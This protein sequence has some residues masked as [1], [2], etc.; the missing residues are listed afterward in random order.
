MSRHIEKFLTGGAEFPLLSVSRIGAGSGGDGGVHFGGSDESSF[1]APLTINRQEYEEILHA[2]S[3]SVEVLRSPSGT[4][5][6]G[7]RFG[8]QSKRIAFFSTNNSGASTN[9]PNMGDGA[10]YA[11]VAQEFGYGFD[12]Y[13]LPGNSLS[14]V[15]SRK[16]RKRYARTGSFTNSDTSNSGLVLTDFAEEVM[17][18]MQHG[19]VPLPEHLWSKGHGGLLTT[20]IAASGETAVR[21]I[22]QAERPGLVGRSLFDV[23]ALQSRDE[24]RAQP[25]VEYP[26][27]DPYGPRVVGEELM[28]LLSPDYRRLRN[29]FLRS[30]SM[31]LPHFQAARRG[32]GENY[33][34]S[35][36]TDMKAVLAR[37]PGV[38]IRFVCAGND[39]LT[40]DR[41]EM[42]NIMSAIIDEREGRVE[43]LIIPDATRRSLTDSPQVIAAA[44]RGALE[45]TEGTKE[46]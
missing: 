2:M 35:V 18:A 3:G 45:S 43:G 40:P 36:V 4:S 46:Q 29:S 6:E 13:A 1:M 19:G 23:I 42:L 15:P 12:W 26:A 44:F 31:L 22:V 27:L 20:A 24:A 21:S 34:G 37:N 10:Q 38:L 41:K 16:D 33:D 14:S 32:P 28:S 9:P 17:V 30:P 25:G 11:Y 5:L 39:V 7:I 8:T